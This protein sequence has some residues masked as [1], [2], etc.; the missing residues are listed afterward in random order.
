MPRMQL[1]L[2]RLTDKRT[3]LSQTQLYY[4][5]TAPCFLVHQ[6]G[7]GGPTLLYLNKFDSMPRVLGLFSQASFYADR[8]GQAG[9]TEQANWLW[10]YM[11]VAVYLLSLLRFRFLT[12]MESFCS[13]LSLPSTRKKPDR[14]RARSNHKSYYESIAS[15]IKLFLYMWER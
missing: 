11:V 14:A 9:N 3:Q 13:K 1:E 8:S 5:I 7:E 2:P 12:L 15:P 6:V 10:T 4:G